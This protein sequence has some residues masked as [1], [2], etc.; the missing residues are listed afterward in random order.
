LAN[1]G[2]GIAADAMLADAARCVLAPPQ[3]AKRMAKRMMV[4]LLF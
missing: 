3:S 2:R 1:G 4:M